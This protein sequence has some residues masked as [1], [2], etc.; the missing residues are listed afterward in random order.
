MLPSYQDDA[1][2]KLEERQIPSACV[3]LL[4]SAQTSGNLGSTS[5]R[6]RQRKQNKSNI[7]YLNF[8]DGNAALAWLHENTPSF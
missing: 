7:D 2:L 8:T 6:V 4:F 1:E 3:A 5:A